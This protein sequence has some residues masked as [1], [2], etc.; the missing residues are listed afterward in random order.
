M[1]SALRHHADT[2]SLLRQGETCW[3]TAAATRATLLVDGEQN[4]GA[5]RRKHLESCG[6]RFHEDGDHP[7]TACVHH[8]IVVIDD[9]RAFCGGIDLTHQRW[10]TCRHEPGDPRDDI[11]IPDALRAVRRDLPSPVARL[12]ERR[13]VQ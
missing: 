1:R 8:K 12:F 6:V 10:D 2:Y 11:W 5:L 7:L 9:V 13:T 4:F 3:R